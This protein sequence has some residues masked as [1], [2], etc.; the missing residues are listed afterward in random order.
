[1]PIYPC[2]DKPNYNWQLGLF[3]H[4]FQS[5]RRLSMQQVDPDDLVQVLRTRYMFQ[6]V[7]SP[8]LDL[9]IRDVPTG[10]DLVLW[11]IESLFPVLINFP[12]LCNLSIQPGNASHHPIVAITP[13]VLDTLSKLP[14][15]S[16]TLAGM[17]CLPSPWP[18]NFTTSW[19]P[20]TKLSLPQWIYYPVLLFCPN[21]IISD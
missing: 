1:M 19:P 12:H 20:A 15:Q 11:A 5:L 8:K 14:L 13:S 4:S 3:N 16:V 21:S 18:D 17:M 7:T 2:S 10:N 9:H 6:H